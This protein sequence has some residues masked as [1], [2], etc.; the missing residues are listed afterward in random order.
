[1]VVVVVVVLCIYY[2]DVIDNAVFVND[3]PFILCVQ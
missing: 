2:F 3:E 1:M